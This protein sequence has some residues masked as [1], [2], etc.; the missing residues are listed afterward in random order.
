[1]RFSCCLLR[2][3]AGFAVGLKQRKFMDLPSPTP[4]ERE[5][6]RFTASFRLLCLHQQGKKKL[7]G[8]FS[9]QNSVLLEVT[10]T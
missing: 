4:G 2:I 7:P 5:G 9:C 3:G 6:Q 10:K 1:M 8:K